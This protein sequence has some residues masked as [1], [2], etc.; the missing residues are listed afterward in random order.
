MFVHFM[1]AV[2]AAIP[3]GEGQTFYVRLLDMAQKLSEHRDERVSK[4]L[5][6]IPPTLAGLVNTIA[7]VLLL[8]VFVYPFHYGLAGGACFVVVAAVLYL[9]NFVMTDTDNPLKGVWNVSPEPFAD[10]RP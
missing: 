1:N 9:A 5:T 2:V 3:K 7:A 6:R 4:S 10:L 8:L